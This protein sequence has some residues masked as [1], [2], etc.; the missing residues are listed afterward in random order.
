MDQGTEVAWQVLDYEREALQKYRRAVARL[1]LLE[2]PQ[3]VK[4]LHKELLK[5]DALAL[6]VAGIGTRTQAVDDLLLAS[7][8]HLALDDQP[9]PR[10]A[11][12]FAAAN[13]RVK[14]GLRSEEHTSELQ[15]RGHLVC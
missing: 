15:S 7:A 6:A 2:N 12:Q 10:N 14:S 5:D 13:A 3:T 1:L 8:A 11:E 9:L 4:Y